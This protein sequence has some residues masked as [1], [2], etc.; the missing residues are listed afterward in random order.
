MANFYW[1]GQRR[2]QVTGIT[3]FDFNEPSNW[4]IFENRTIDDGCVPF[5][6]TLGGAIV[7]EVSASR[8]IGIENY[9]VNEEGSGYGWGGD[10]NVC[11]VYAAAARAPG[12]GDVVVIGDDIPLGQ[13]PLL[14]GGFIGGETGGIWLNGAD[15]GAGGYTHASGGTTDSSL[16]AF[17]YGGMGLGHPDFNYPWQRIG[18]GFTANS[19]KYGKYT[20]GSKPEGLLSFA[21]L[22]WKL[23][24][25][26][27]ATWTVVNP[28][29]STRVAEVDS[30]IFSGATWTAGQLTSR[31]Q[32]LRIKADFIEEAVRDYVGCPHY[33]DLE[34]VKNIKPATDPVLQTV[35]NR[36][37]TNYV[38]Y[39]RNVTSFLKGYV[40]LLQNKSAETRYKDWPGGNGDTFDDQVHDVYY[41]TPDERLVLD[42]VTAASIRS[43]VPDQITVLQN[44][45]CGSMHIDDR[46]AI[47]D[48]AVYCLNRTRKHYIGGVINT[49]KCLTDLGLTGTAEAQDLDNTLLVKASTSSFGVERGAAPGAFSVYVGNYTGLTG[50]TC[51]IA[52]INVDITQDLRA[53]HPSYNNRPASLI[54][55]G[56]APQTINTLLTKWCNVYAEDIAKETPIYIGVFQLG[57]KAWFYPNLNDHPNWFFGTRYTGAPGT[58]IG[59]IQ[60]LQDANTSDTDLTSEFI[61]S[62][63][64]RLHNA[65]VGLTAPASLTVTPVF[66]GTAGIAT[67]IKGGLGGV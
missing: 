48:D 11:R 7:L 64:F 37:I 23:Y 21:D 34:I 31:T 32:S 12:P 60:F 45:V 26:S 17:Y 38:R 39:S 35:Y 40:R 33:A 6:S 3:A 43:Y 29:G 14:F 62:P 46:F 16:A 50:I 19:E 2:D 27:G 44:T 57:E 63:Y 66:R 53:S 18:G 51:D 20:T 8:G 22:L 4:L 65:M 67:L 42:G 41:L 36:V 52:K 49:D 54:F 24:F 47:E 13:T 56:T 59:G 15:D 25:Q 9:G 5:Q 28:D 1:R 58:F 10:S 30:A 55:Y 61:V